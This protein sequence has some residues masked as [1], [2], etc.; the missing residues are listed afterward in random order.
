MPKLKERSSDDKIKRPGK[1]RKPKGPLRQMTTKFR[2]R[3]VERQR[4]NSST[5]TPDT[6]A[7]EQSVQA[8]MDA[9]E[10]VGY[11]AEKAVDRLLHRAH[12]PKPRKEQIKEGGRHPKEKTDMVPSVNDTLRDGKTIH[13]NTPDSLHNVSQLTPETRMKQQAVEKLEHSVRADHPKNGQFREVPHYGGTPQN[14]YTTKKER[15]PGNQSIHQGAPPALLRAK[16]K[17]ARW[18]VYTQDT[19]SYGQIRPG[20][21]ECGQNNCPKDRRDARS[22][23]SNGACSPEGTDRRPAEYAAKIQADG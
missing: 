2:C 6:Q 3:L 8:G 5:A 16:R 11:R 20:I 7:A 15:S 23:A 13:P 4:D 21:N 22:Q 1:D 10:E 12:R 18:G 19:K 17:A 14:T 9:V